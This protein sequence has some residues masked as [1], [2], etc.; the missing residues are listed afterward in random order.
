MYPEPIWIS[1]QQFKEY[2]TVDERDSFNYLSVYFNVKDDPH[3][4]LY[5]LLLH[6]VSSL[7]QGKVEPVMGCA[8]NILAI[9]G[10]CLCFLR[11][12]RLLEAQGILPVG[13]GRIL[14]LG[15]CLVYGLSQ[16]AVAATLLIRMYGLLSFWCVAFFVMHVRRW[17]GEGFCG[18]NKRLGT[19][20]R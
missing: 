14:G 13:Y 9:L 7:F 8:I 20:D 19:V 5:Y 4:P 16:G 12:G 15:A 10:C 3:P 17:L 2:I 1:A 6:T 18:N 11:L